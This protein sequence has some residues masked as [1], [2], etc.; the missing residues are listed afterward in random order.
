[1]IPD[2]RKALEAL[3]DRYTELVN[4]GDCGNWNPE[5]EQVVIDARSAL[6][7]ADPAPVNLRL[8]VDSNDKV[9]ISV[10]RKLAD[11]RDGQIIM[12]DA[13]EMVAVQDKDRVF[14]LRT[15]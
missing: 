2:C 15:N 4:S 1:M 9:A 8:L 6:V 12:F 10:G 13:E 7:R 3:L 14:V 5:E 11:S